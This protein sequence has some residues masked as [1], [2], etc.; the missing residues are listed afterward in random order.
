MVRSTLDLVECQSRMMQPDA[1]AAA[2][3]RHFYMTRV[4]KNQN[5]MV[6]LSND[7]TYFWKN[8][9]KIC[10]ERDCWRFW[11]WLR[12]Y[13]STGEFEQAVLNE[14]IKFYTYLILQI[15]VKNCLVFRVW[16]QKSFWIGDCCSRCWAKSWNCYYELGW[17][18]RS[19]KRDCLWRCEIYSKSWGW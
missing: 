8:C 5:G 18:W 16:R 15:E 9:W 6:K 1:L 13:C 10:W 2:I 19:S 12:S 11:R 17:N 14:Q 3:T 7:C 4:F